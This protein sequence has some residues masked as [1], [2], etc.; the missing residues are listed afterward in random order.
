MQTAPDLEDDPDED[1]QTRW[2]VDPSPWAWLRWIFSQ[3]LRDY[4][5]RARFLDYG[6]T[7]MDAAIL[8]RSLWSVEAVLRRLLLA[9]ALALNIVPR[10]PRSKTGAKTGQTT[11]TPSQPAPAAPKEKPDRPF[12]VFAIHRPLQAGPGA[13]PRAIRTPTS[14][15][16]S[17]FLPADPLLTIGAEQRPPRGH[18]FRYLESSNPYD[19][20]IR[21]PAPILLGRL[22]T[23]LRI[24]REP[25]A[26]TRRLALLLAR[27]TGAVQRLAEAGAPYWTGHERFHRP[28]GLEEMEITQK[29][30]DAALGYPAFDTS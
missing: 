21:R 11:E 15:S 6:L 13:Q 25:E 3:I 17:T 14:P 19:D 9:A 29:A 30:L 5:E 27:R 28:P 12:R 1:E 20:N 26:A 24:F 16:Y 7:R 18:A 23:V 4:P 10:P 8:A 22:V 2:P